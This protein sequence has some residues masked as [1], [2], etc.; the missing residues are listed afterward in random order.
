[1]ETL[2][3]L[4]GPEILMIFGVIILLTLMFAFVRFWIKRKRAAYF[5]SRIEEAWD[6]CLSRYRAS[7]DLDK[8]V[9]IEEVTGF[10]SGAVYCGNTELHYVF[11]NRTIAGSLGSI[12]F[13]K[14]CE[15][16]KTTAPETMVIPFDDLI[17][18]KLDTSNRKRPQAILRYRNAVKEIEYTFYNP[19]VY[20]RLK[21]RFPEKE[22]SAY[23]A[24]QRQQSTNRTEAFRKR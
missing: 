24:A 9:Y 7:H 17:W 18:F 1:M 22:F 6:I 16:I 14:A 3:S 13:E 19:E 4:S 11:R 15:R 21:W 20:Q 8:A 12:E 23:S 2:K 10:N 5:E